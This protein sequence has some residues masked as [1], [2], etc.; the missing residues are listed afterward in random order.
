MR[1]P[2]QLS[3]VVVILLTAASSVGAAPLVKKWDHFGF[4][5]DYTWLAFG[6]DGKS[7]ALA[8]G[9]EVWL[10]DP[11]DPKFQRPPED[12]KARLPKFILKGHKGRVIF[13]AFTADGKILASADVTGTVKLWDVAG[14]TERASFDT[15]AQSVPVPTDYGRNETCPALFALAPDGRSFATYRPEPKRKTGELKLWDTTSGKSRVLIAHRDLVHALAFSPDGKTLATASGDHTAMLWDATTGRKTRTLREHTGPVW[16][17]AFSPDG[18]TL[19][20]EASDR[21]L[22]LWDVTT[23]QD[24]TSLDIEDENDKARAPV[25]RALTFSPDGKT[26][27]RFRP[28][29]DTAELRDVAT[30][31]RWAMLSGGVHNRGVALAFSPD[32]KWVGGIAGSGDSP[33]TAYMWSVPKLLEPKPDK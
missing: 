30:G 7:V 19:A 4:N 33:T 17:V 5:P 16:A 13:L 24:H 31:K 11:A 12:H 9:E 6:P 10:D 8:F 21:L 1:H 26:L 23:G 20:T 14:R 32:G 27:A 3:W 22:K 29:S 18:K 25:L 28:N 15:G 2:I